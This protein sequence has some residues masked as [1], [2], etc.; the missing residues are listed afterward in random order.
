[1]I[2]PLLVCKLLHIL[3]VADI[4]ID[5]LI[6]KSLSPPSSPL[7][8]DEDTTR[9]TS[10]SVS[11]SAADLPPISTFANSGTKED[12]ERDD[13]DIPTCRICLD[14]EDESGELGRLLAPCKCSGTVRLPFSPF[15]L[16][17]T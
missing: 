11:T 13:L 6:S 7:K 17:R 14:G 1:L 10:V 4:F 2:H 15:F 9:A 3:L 5:L 8:M 16:L 12:G